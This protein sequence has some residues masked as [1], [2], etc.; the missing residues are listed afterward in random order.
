MASTSKDPVLTAIV[1]DVL[2]EDERE[3]TKR[4]RNKNDDEKPV[5]KSVRFSTQNVVHEFADEDEVT[6]VCNDC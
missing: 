6:E 4:K 1:D 3:R 2:G 5:K